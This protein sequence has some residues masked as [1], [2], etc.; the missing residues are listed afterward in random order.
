MFRDVQ[1]K[2]VESTEE[3][4]QK[5]FSQAYTEHG[6]GIIRYLISSGMQT[7]DAQDVLQN[8][9][10]AMWELRFRIENTKELAPLWFTIARHKMFDLFRKNR[11]SLPLPTESERI[12]DPRNDFREI[13][14]ASLRRRIA[15]ELNRLP[16]EMSEAYRLTKISG[17]SIREAAEIMGI[18][19]SDLKSKVF[20]A[21]KKL[22]EALVDW[23]D[24]YEN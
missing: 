14:Q 3:R 8:S 24:F 10:L 22:M 11:R 19:E 17:L 2:L 15:D 13:D 12:P 7:A 18:T 20:R 1:G 6:P 16:E 23:K 9:F 21:R 5:D 4:L